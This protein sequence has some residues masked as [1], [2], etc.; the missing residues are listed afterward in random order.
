MSGKFLAHFPAVIASLLLLLNILGFPNVAQAEVGEKRRIAVMPFDYGSVMSVV[1]AHDVGSGIVA[2]LITRLVQDGTYTVVDRQ[3]LDSIIKEQNLSMSGRADPATALKIGKLLNVDAM[4]VGTVTQ[5]GF[6][7]KNMNLGAAASAVGRFSP[8]GGFGFGG[9]GSRKSKVHVA[10]DARLVDCNTGEILATCQGT[11]ESNRGGMSLFGGGGGGGGGGSGNFDMGSS[12]FASSIAGE[13]TLAAVDSMTP[14]MIAWSP[15][16]PNSLKLLADTAEGKVADVEGL[17]VI[18]NIGKKSGLQV[19][20]NLQVERPYKTVTDPTTGKILKQLTN[21]V[22]VLKLGEV[23][24]ESA[25]GNVVKGSGVVVGDN[26][27]KVSAD[28]SAV[29]I[30]PS[31]NP[32]TQTAPTATSTTATKSTK[33]TIKRKLN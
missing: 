12:D 6:E 25:T 2:L 17:Q 8:Y 32:T 13:A 23:D 22:A 27:R 16:I 33:A 20:D 5:F 11:G 10:I 21:T 3:M 15:K 19:G 31:A 9:V 29:I 30:S 7:T 26:V 28:V 18:V 24:P 4:V 1:G 14:Q